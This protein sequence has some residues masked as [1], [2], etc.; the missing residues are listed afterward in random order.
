MEKIEISKEEMTKFIKSGNLYFAHPINLG[1]G[2]YPVKSM[3]KLKEITMES[4]ESENYSEVMEI[5]TYW[6]NRETPLFD[7]IVMADNN[8]LNLNMDNVKLK[9]ELSD[10]SLF[11]MYWFKDN[12][13]SVGMI[14][15]S[16]Q[17]DI[18][19]PRNT[20]LEKYTRNN[21]EIAKAN[22]DFI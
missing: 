11:G 10:C 5:F 4:N 9:Y 17:L 7:I 18:P 21:Y 3:K 6:E 20:D 13:P 2:I 15:V 16:E 14:N 12:T 8:Y 1:S 22:F 19:M